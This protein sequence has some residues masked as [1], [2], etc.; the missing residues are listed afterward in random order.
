VGVVSVS[1]CL[2]CLSACLSGGR[3]VRAIDGMSRI[4]PSLYLKIIAHRPERTMRTP[5][6]D[7]PQR[8]QRQEDSREGGGQPGRQSIENHHTATVSPR[9]HRPTP[10]MLVSAGS[11]LP[12]TPPPRQMSCL[13]ATSR[14]LLGGSRTSSYWPLMPPLKVP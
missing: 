2:R 4:L 7:I 12:S 8:G 1:V 14:H 3:C 10:S 9:W 13:I 11:P 6:E 5:A